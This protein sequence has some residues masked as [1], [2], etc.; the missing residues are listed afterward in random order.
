LEDL[1]QGTIKYL[2]ILPQPGLRP[3]THY[4]FVSTR[5]ERREYERAQILYIDKF[6]IV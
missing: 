1:L 2:P 6:F 4:E 3:S 5:N